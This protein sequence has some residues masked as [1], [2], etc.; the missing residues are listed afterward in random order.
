MSSLRE[1]KRLVREQILYGSRES[2]FQ[3][4]LHSGAFRYNGK[5]FMVMGDK[6]SGKTSTILSMLHE[7]SDFISNDLIFLKKEDGFYVLGTP[8]SIRIGIG[9]AKQYKELESLI[10]NQF[11]ELESNSLELWKVPKNIKTEIEWYELDRLFSTKVLTSWTKMHFVI[12][13]KINRELIKPIVEYLDSDKLYEYLNNNNLSTYKGDA[14]NGPWL[15]SIKVDKK[16]I[17]DNQ[18]EIFNKAS[19]SLKG[20]SIVFNG[21]KYQLKEAINDILIKE[22]NL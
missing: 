14:Q 3:I 19:Q 2:K 7:G 21:D 9:T 20:I 13:P 16:A 4:P 18:N 5:G 15:S 6:G 17:L 22:D 12:F 11:K 8:E 10:P 1:I